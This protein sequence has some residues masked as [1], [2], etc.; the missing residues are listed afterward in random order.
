MA[1]GPGTDK[2]KAKD[3]GFSSYRITI[4]DS[5][6][7]HI[8]YQAKTVD[9]D[10]TYA[11]PIYFGNVSANAVKN[12]AG[13]PRGGKFTNIRLSA[14]LENG[15]ASPYFASL[16][17]TATPLGITGLSYGNAGF[18]EPTGLINAVYATPPV[19][20][21]DFPHDVFDADGNYTIKAW[22][23]NEDGDRISAI[24]SIT[25]NT[26]EGNTKSVS[27]YTGYSGESRGWGTTGATVLQI[28]GLTIQK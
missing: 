11:G 4:E 10:K 18:G 1:H 12:E 14:R 16:H 3:T 20:Y 9:A 26:Q 27:A 23:E 13:F 22:A 5:N 24:A 6:G 8:G 17:A 2:T 25:I 28:Y 21:F 15:P 7:D 19:E